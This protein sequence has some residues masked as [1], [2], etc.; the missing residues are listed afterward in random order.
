MTTYNIHSGF[1]YLVYQSTDKNNEFG[2]LITTTFILSLGSVL[3]S[4]ILH[5]AVSLLRPEQTKLFIKNSHGIID[6]PLYFCLTGILCML[7][8]VWDV[9]LYMWCGNDLSCWYIR[10]LIFVV[11]FFA[12]CIALKIAHTMDIIG[13]RQT[14]EMQKKHDGDYAPIADEV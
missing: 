13:V 7:G 10:T 12:I 6:V 8:S 5:G 3:L 1:T 9:S 2:F 11:L 4:S 14:L